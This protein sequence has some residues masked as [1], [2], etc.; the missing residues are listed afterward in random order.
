MNT[1]PYRLSTASAL[2]AALAL[3][4]ITAPASAATHCVTF[5][6][7]PFGANYVAPFVADGVTITPRELYNIVSHPCAGPIPFNWAR[8]DTAALVPG[9]SA[10][11]SLQLNT[12]RLEFSMVD[13]MTALGGVPVRKLQL[14][15]RELGPTR[16]NIAVNG[17]CYAVNHFTDIP[18]GTII[19]GAKYRRTAS[20]IKL[21]AKRGLAIRLFE[22]GGGEL[23][24]DNVCAKD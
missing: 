14:N 18:N 6:G 16:F 19:G 20:K 15:Y 24:I 7:L 1:S 23:A 12:T 13:F 22:I 5:D 17:D 10:P 21:K 3:A 9:A 11:H 2:L 8:V 4:S